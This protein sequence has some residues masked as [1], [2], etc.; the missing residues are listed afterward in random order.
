MAA[1]A[2]PTAGRSAAEVA[3][4]I[5]QRVAGLDI[6]CANCHAVAERMVTGQCNGMDCDCL[7]IQQ[8]DQARPGNMT[9]SIRC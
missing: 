7:N 1:R 9:E 8:T 2:G 4:S 6:D 5:L 3:Q